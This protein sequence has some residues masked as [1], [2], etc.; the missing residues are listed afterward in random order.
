MATDRM[1]LGENV[2]YSTDSNET[3][4]NNNVLVCGSSGCGKT[5]SISEPRLLETYHTSLIATVTKRRIVNKYKPTFEKRGYVVEDLN[6]IHPME[7]NVAYDPLQYISSYSDI[8]FLAESIVRAN[9]RKDKSSADP[10]WDEAA[11]SLLSAEIAYT[12][13]TKDNA[14]FADV[15]ELHDG[16]DFRENG[17]Q[18]TTSLDRKFEYL[19]EKDPGCFAVSC[20]KSFHQLPIKTASCVFGTLN[21]T[22][23]TIFSPELRKMIA[24]EKKVDFEKM[25]TQKTILFVSTSAVNPALHCFINIFYAQAFKALFEYA[26]S[27]PGGK[28]PIPVHVLCDDFA[29]G[30]RILNFPE[31]IS[32]FREKQIS[33]T[34]LVQSESQLE[35]MYGSDD[36]T[37]IINNCDTYLYMGG[38]D[39]KTGRSISERLNT[40]LEDVLYMPIGQVCIFRRGQKPIITSRYDILEDERFQQVTRAYEDSIRERE[41]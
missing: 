12:L 15:L 38:M 29:T 6:F 17:G 1:I 14:T 23:D 18:I 3:G 5:M 2:V 36:A 4:L 24:M 7:S 26:E 25:A 11:T 39:L 19:A 21:T 13:M 22:I 34:L 27:L 30:S 32:I 28:L 33:V 16:I 9:P 37:T 20:W 31:Y 41:Y 40:P 8:T 35:S 10:Y